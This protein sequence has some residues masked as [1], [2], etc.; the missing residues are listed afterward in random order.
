MEIKHKGYEDFKSLVEID[1]KDIIEIHENFN[2]GFSRGFGTG[3]RPN[4]FSLSSKF[5]VQGDLKNWGVS[6][7]PIEIPEQ[8]KRSSGFNSSASLAIQQIPLEQSFNF[9]H[10]FN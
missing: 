8:K 1:K 4:S 2:N 6:N 9:G 5:G 10:Q 7:I 3:N